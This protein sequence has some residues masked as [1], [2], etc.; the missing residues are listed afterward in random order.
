MLFC[1]SARW[2][3]NH[4]FSI[5]IDD[6]QPG[7]LLN[8]DKEGKIS[9]G[10]VQCDELINKYNNGKIELL[11][12]CDAAQTLETLIA[13]VLNDIRGEAAKVHT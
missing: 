12:G 7:D 11:P 9:D 4:G 10:N 2:I 8:K 3:G 5:G 1:Y 6:V 13:K